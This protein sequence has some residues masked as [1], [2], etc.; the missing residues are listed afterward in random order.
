MYC[1]FLYKGLNPIRRKPS[2]T[3]VDCKRTGRHG[4]NDVIG[5]L[6]MGGV[7]LS[8]SIDDIVGA[9][10]RGLEV[11][12]RCKR[13]SCLIASLYANYRCLV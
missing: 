11:P 5:T 13:D 10:R 1:M 7:G 6:M 8:P 12:A 3:E 2:I 4:V 9:A